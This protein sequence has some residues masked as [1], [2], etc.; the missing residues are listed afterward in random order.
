MYESKK[1]SGRKDNYKYQKS[2]HQKN[3]HNTT[4]FGYHKY[5]KYKQ[6][7]TRSNSIHDYDEESLFSQIF[8]E[9]KTTKKT[10]LK[11]VDDLTPTPTIKT[12]KTLT[13]NKENFSFNSNINEMTT[14]MKTY[15]INEPNELNNKEINEDVTSFNNSNSNNPS[16]KLIICEKEKE[17]K[18]QENNNEVNNENINFNINNI[19]NINFNVENVINDLLIKNNEFFSSNEKENIHLEY[20]KNVYK[21]PQPFK[22]N[23][24]S[25]INISSNDMKEAY[26]V[27]KKLSTIYDMYATQQQPNL[28][29]RRRNSINNFNFMTIQKPN[30]SLSNKQIPNYTNLGI[31]NN[32]NLNFFKNNNNNN[33][34]RFNNGNNNI[35]MTNNF[36]IPNSPNI[37]I[38][39]FNLFES[40]NI[41]NIGNIN[42][43][44]NLQQCLN[45]GNSLHHNL[46]KN[47]FHNMMPQLELNK[48][49]LKTQINNN[50]LFE[51][52]KENTDILEI[53]VKITDTET[54]TFKIRRYDDMF[55]TVKMFC[56]INKLDIKLIRPFIIYIIR[57]LNSI[58]GVYN[59]KLKNE[60]IQFLKDIKNNF[61]SQEE[62]EDINEDQKEEEDD[63]EKKDDYRGEKFN[64]EDKGSIISNSKDNDGEDEGSGTDEEE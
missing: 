13:E 62:E 36:S 3:F 6:K 1:N 53:N 4:H 46:N 55:K 37:P 16:E 26:Y 52:D 2:S 63:D 60:E 19:D 7:Y 14:Q 30:I 43:L 33:F 32:V 25:S 9:N 15:D 51:K 50:N 34:M 18:E 11:E 21:T 45:H 5:N 42:N 22:A 31:S 57:A 28:F 38:T 40:N 54:L 20:K 27:P 8:E 59:L 12:C 58:Y 10:D 41:N 35:S 39:S 61:Y 64:F 48:C 24:S 56:E 17:N 49:I 29:D 47:P 23:S 44:P